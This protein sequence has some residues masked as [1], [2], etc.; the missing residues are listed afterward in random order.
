MLRKKENP[1]KRPSQFLQFTKLHT[2]YIFQ[3][4]TNMYEWPDCGLE[5]MKTRMRANVVKEEGHPGG[6]DRGG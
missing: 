4:D 5:G 6:E 1:E 3:K 2:P